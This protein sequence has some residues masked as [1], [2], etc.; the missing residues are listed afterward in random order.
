MSQSSTVEVEARTEQEDNTQKREFILVQIQNLLANL[1]HTSSK[2]LNSISSNSTSGS[3]LPQFR[4][5][6]QESTHTQNTTSSSMAIDQRSVDKF[7]TE[8]MICSSCYGD[9]FIV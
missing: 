4:K 3:S 7:R 8:T 6:N 9:L 5:I 2:A 1:T